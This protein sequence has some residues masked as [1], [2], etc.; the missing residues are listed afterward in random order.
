MT[1]LIIGFVAGAVFKVLVPWPAA[2][3]KV[4]EAWAWGWAKVRR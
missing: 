4:R 1:W 2:D 3:D